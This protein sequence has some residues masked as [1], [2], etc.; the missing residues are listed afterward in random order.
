MCTGCGG[1]PDYTL[2]LI[3]S[4]QNRQDCQIN[5]THT[6]L[7]TKKQALYYF[8]LEDT[9]LVLVLVKISYRQK[10]LMLSDAYNVNCFKCNDA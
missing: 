6:R 10:L 8:F 1:A 2:D 5:F 3:T 7:D 9:I 4:L